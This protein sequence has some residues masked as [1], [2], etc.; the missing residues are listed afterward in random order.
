MKPKVKPYK[1][2]YYEL[3]NKRRGMPFNVRHESWLD[4]INGR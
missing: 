3:V 1:P 4:Y 2:D